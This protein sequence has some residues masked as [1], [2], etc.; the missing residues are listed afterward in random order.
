MQSAACCN[1][2][3]SSALS[4][5]RFQY[6]VKGQAQTLSRGGTVCY[7]VWDG[8]EGLHSAD[9]WKQLRMEHRPVRKRVGK[10]ERAE[11]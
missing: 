2:L 6:K 7:Y 4:A 11:V 9:V 5:V 8:G 3:P 1:I 10:R